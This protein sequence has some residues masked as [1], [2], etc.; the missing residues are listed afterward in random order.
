M[1]VDFAYSG[2]LDA[3]RRRMKILRLSAF[4]LSMNRLVDLI[5]HC[6][7]RMEDE[8]EESKDRESP[9]YLFSRHIETVHYCMTCACV[10]FHCAAA[11]P[12]RCLSAA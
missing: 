1:L 12:L 3:G 6:I 8:D 2:V 4:E 11:G 9:I 7:S 5:D 10:T